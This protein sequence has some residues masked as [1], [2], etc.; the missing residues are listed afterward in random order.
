M[1]LKSGFGTSWRRIRL[2]EHR[3]SLLRESRQEGG[4]AEG[5]LLLHAREAVGL[6]LDAGL[7]DEDT[8][9]GGEAGEGEDAELVDRHDLA[10]EASAQC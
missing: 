8:G 1:A 2:E 5:P 7:V 3:L 9:V 10:R 6:G 4:D